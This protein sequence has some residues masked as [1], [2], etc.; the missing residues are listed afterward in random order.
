MD[1][2]F[3]DGLEVGGPVTIVLLD[4]KTGMSPS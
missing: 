4:V 3:Y 2:I 1:Y